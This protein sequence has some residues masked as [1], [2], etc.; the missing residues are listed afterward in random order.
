MVNTQI[1]KALEAAVA[2]SEAADYKVKYDILHTA[3]KRIIRESTPHPVE[4]WKNGSYSEKE[5]KRA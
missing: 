4:N 1:I 5:S 3:C 2:K